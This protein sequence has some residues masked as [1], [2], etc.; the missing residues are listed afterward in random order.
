MRLRKISHAK[1]RNVGSCHCRPH[2]VCTAHPP[3]TD[4]AGGPTRRMRDMRRACWLALLAGSCQAFDQGQVNSALVETGGPEVLVDLSRIEDIELRYYDVLE[5]GAGEVA[6]EIILAG[7]GGRGAGNPADETWNMQLLEMDGTTTTVI[8]DRGFTANG[9]MRKF[10]TANG[11]RYYAFGGEYIDD[12]EAEWQPG[13]PRDGVHVVACDTLGTRNDPRGTDSIFGGCMYSPS[14]GYSEVNGNWEVSPHQFAFDGWH[15]GRHDARGGANN[16]MMFDGKLS[17]V[18]KDGWWLVYAR[19]NLQYHGGRF[20][21]VARTR[22][23]WSE[24]WGADAYEDFQMIEIDGYDRD[25]PGNVYFAGIDRHPLDPD[26]LVGLFPINY[27]QPGR[28]DGDGESFIGLSMSCDGVHWGS[29]TQ[30]VWSVGREGRTYDHPVDGMVLEADGRVA[31]LVHQNVQGISPHAPQDSKIVKYHFQTGAF[32]DLTDRMRQTVVG[33]PGPVVPGASTTAPSASSS[34]PPPSTSPSPPPS[35]SPSP[36][37]SASPLPPPSSLPS[38]PPSA[39]PSPPPSALPSPLPVPPPLPSPSPQSSPPLPAPPS[40]PP[41]RPSPPP[42]WTPSPPWLGPD[43]PNAGAAIISQQTTSSPSSPHVVV[44]VIFAI[45]GVM[46]IVGGIMMFLCARLNLQPPRMSPSGSASRRCAPMMSRASAKG[47]P[48]RIN[49][50]EEG[51][52]EEE[53]SSMRTRRKLPALGVPHKK[54]REIHSAVEMAEADLELEDGDIGRR[55]IRRPSSSEPTDRLTAAMAH[56]AHIKQMGEL[57]D[58]ARQA[59]EQRG[60]EA[61]EVFDSA[62]LRSPRARSLSADLD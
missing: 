4:T 57:N 42:S 10:A 41:A 39:S 35:A 45:S 30:L 14:H 29:F 9:F 55:A 50:Y 3:A 33:C 52:D 27:G 25:G 17:A 24:P 13:D 11:T 26:M 43:L 62:N 47:K 22:Q 32:N 8:W 56:A 37:P 16:V 28:H 7:R 6:S 19:A 34:P 12:G 49:S 15:G 23:Q 44:P 31:F 40:P 54:A 46:L 5:P 60:Q 53:G 59:E 20:V 51:D 48:S 58:A 1:S 38:P 61:L 36:P 18:Y 2:R 21:V